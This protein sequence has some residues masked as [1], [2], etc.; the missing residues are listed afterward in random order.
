MNKVDATVIFDDG[1]IH[2]ID[3]FINDNILVLDN[4]NDEPTTI[5]LFS[6]GAIF[7]D[8]WIYNKSKFIMLGGS[9][10]GGGRHFYA[11][12]YAKV[13]I[14]EGN[15]GGELRVHDYSK[16]TI[17]DGSINSSLI[18]NDNC[19]II[20]NGGAIGTIGRD[21]HSYNDSKIVMTGG[22][23]SNHLYTHNNSEVTLRG[24]SIVYDL[25]T[26]DDSK[27]LISGG[28]IGRK[29]NPKYNSGITILGWGFNYGYGYI[30]DPSGRLV[31]ILAN[32][33]SIDVDFI[34]EGNGTILLVQPSISDINYDGIV[35][36]VDFA[37]L[38]YYWQ[39]M[40]CASYEN[41]ENTDF[42]PDGDVDIEDLLIIMNDWLLKTIP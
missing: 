17:S 37:K 5:Y 2:E 27:V 26:N 21:V 8:V 34:R 1:D 3:Y 40:E 35:N 4:Y 31:G 20:I 16:I 11:Y 10:G 7:Y 41:C 32:G 18:A 38:C 36:L 6:E 39:E 42:E 22:T 25:Y 15:I 33:D 12:N 13:E 29:I 14:L 9:T 23:L 24:G 28:S 19:N 30:T